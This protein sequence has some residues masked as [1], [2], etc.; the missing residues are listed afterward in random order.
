MKPTVTILLPVYNAEQTVSETIDSILV[1]TYSNFELLIINDGSDDRSEEII[2]S[3][4]D[5]RIR[6]YAN[7]ENRGL[8]Y[9]LNRGIEIAEGDYIAR[10]DADDLMLKNRLEVQVDYMERHLDVVALGTAM[11]VMQGNRRKAHCPPV[12][13]IEAYMYYGCPLIHPSAIIR[14]AVLWEHHIKYD[15]DYKHA[16]DYKFWYDLSKVG[17]LVNISDRLLIYRVSDSQVSKVYHSQQLNTARRVKALLIEDFRK[18]YNIDF[19][20]NRDIHS[21]IALER[22]IKG[23]KIGSDELEEYYAVLLAC[24]MSVVPKS[25]VVSHFLLSRIWLCKSF[26]IKYTVAILMQGLGLKNFEYLGF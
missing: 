20:I 19:L 8:I 4:S 14:K 1:Q 10:I 13:H 18:K 2:T 6:Y 22:C 3:Y 25:I 21:I 11:T 9:T 16:E 7:Q 23:N 26:P 12:R 15:Y 17:R 5:K 24:Y